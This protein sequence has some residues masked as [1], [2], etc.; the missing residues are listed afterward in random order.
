[1][2]GRFFIVFVGLMYGV[3]LLENCCY[4]LLFVLFSILFVFSPGLVEG[5]HSRDLESEGCHF[6]FYWMID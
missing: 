1:M 5:M 6:V 2:Y 4:W 3:G